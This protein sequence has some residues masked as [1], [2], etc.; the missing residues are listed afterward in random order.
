MQRVIEKLRDLFRG[1]N[2]VW[3]CCILGILGMVMILFSGSPEKAEE[4]NVG[5]QTQICGTDEFC[6]N[7]EAR[8]EELLKN[9]D[10]VGDVRVM[11]T[12]GSSGEYVYAVSSRSDS[13]RKEQD[14]V[15][16][17]K[18]SE[19]EALIQNVLSPKITG[20]VVVCEGGGRDK[21]REEVYNTVSAVLG[22]GSGK[23]YVAQMK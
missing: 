23:I 6:R 1:R 5:E 9:I 21:V 18:G 8:L 3:V 19:E 4:T 22:V 17:K 14:Y 10:G 20:V 15:V 12:A 11:I 16:L 2:A 7:T 13:D